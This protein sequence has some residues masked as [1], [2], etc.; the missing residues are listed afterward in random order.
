MNATRP[1]RNG[2]RS[3]AGGL[4]LLFALSPPAT[5][6]EA[7]DRLNTRPAE[8]PPF[9]Q[10]GPAEAFRLPAVPD[11]P[12]APDAAG[13]AP[14]FVARI[15][16]RGNRAI[17]DAELEALVAPYANRRLG[18]AAREELR[19]KLT[20]HYIERGYVNSG[21]VLADDALQGDTLT[22]DIVEGR[23]RTIRVGGLDGLD[24]R[25]V[26][27]RL[28]GD[29][30]APLNVD[31]LRERFALLVGD[32][33]F[34]R[35]NARLRPSETLGEAILDIDVER[36]RPYRLSV[37]A[38]NHRPPSIGSGALG[39]DASLANLSG[40]GDLLEAGV[41][42]P[43]Q[44]TGGLRGSLAW[45][46][47]LNSRGTQLAL[48]IERGRS[49]V[50]EAPMQT[51][52]IESVLDSREV[53]LAQT[54]LETLRHRLALGVGRVQRENRSTL[55]GQPF[56]FVAG[57]PDGV[58]RIAAW[59]FWQEYSY[60]SETQVLALRS[61]FTSARNNLLP[62]DPLPDPLPA[63]V[64]QPE[65]RYALW[66][67][68]GQW[69]K[70]WPDS[71]A[72]LV[73]RGS[74]QQTTQRLL[75]LDRMSIGGNATVRGYRENQ[76]LRERGFVINVE[77]D[78]PLIRAA[79]PALNL[80]LIPFYDHGRGRNRDEAADTLSSAGLAA[81]LRWQGFSL[82]LAVAKRLRHPAS[83]AHAGGTLQDKGIH[84]QL[85]YRFY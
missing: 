72:Q 57:E 25:Y 29:S 80:S 41:E 31:L 22:I 66:L 37:R 3:L 69:A 82:E 13:H 49:S 21:A 43:T 64:A 67:G 4:G 81:R 79:D 24:E 85:S 33:L 17:P 73:L 34:K 59:R 63:P 36:E 15:V 11:E 70:Q 44:N 56:S 60:R 30:A 83:I 45:R 68:Q 76:L 35:L 23:L 78:T 71:G 28:H 42:A 55:L 19:Q 18:E 77:F 14:V 40:Y 62:P 75:A 50:V 12:P 26:S 58:T 53:G 10:P 48:R 9:L 39:L 65:H 20:R 6:S 74:L 84:C 1:N 5:G 16:L 61:T 8:K 54:L 47:P 38:N 32:P 7:G 52:D 2:R 27:G 51:L 46:M